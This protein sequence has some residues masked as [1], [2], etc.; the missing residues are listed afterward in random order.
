MDRKEF[1]IACAGLLGLEKLLSD[2]YKIKDR[3]KKNALKD[4]QKYFDNVYKNIA[5]VLRQKAYNTDFYGTMGTTAFNFKDKDKRSYYITVAHGLTGKLKDI[6]ISDHE[7][8][9]LPA[10]IE[11]INPPLDLAILSTEADKIK[12]YK[13]DTI[14]AEKLIDGEDAYIVGYPESQYRSVKKTN[15]AA[16][17]K[18]YNRVYIALDELSPV[19]CSGSPLFVTRNGNLKLAGIVAL[20][21]YKTKNT[22]AIPPRYFKDV[23]K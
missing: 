1:F 11:K 17:L 13:I 2:D 3:F 12:A 15:I 19:G 9:H 4:F 10:K 7:N 22:L 5:I 20:L 21:N 8:N 14:P 23:I 18:Y 16:V 6:I